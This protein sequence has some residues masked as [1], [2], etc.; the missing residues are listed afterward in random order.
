MDVEK[1]I[2]SIKDKSIDIVFSQGFLVTMDDE[3][4]KSLLKHLKKNCKRRESF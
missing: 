1:D 4:V 3:K 2:S